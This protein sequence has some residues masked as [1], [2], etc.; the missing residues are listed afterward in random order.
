MYIVN[1][2]GDIDEKLQESVYEQMK[3]WAENHSDEDIAVNVNSIGG[4]IVIAQNINNL[5]YLAKEEKNANIVS[6]NTGDVMSAAT[7]IYLAGDERIWDESKG[8]FLIHR[9][10]IED[11]S[12]NVEEVLDGAIVLNET[13]ESLVEFYKSFNE[14]SMQEI[15]SRMCE[16]RP[17]STEEVIDYKF[18][19]ELI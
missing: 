17:M 9:P 14:K 10:I 7:V 18:A 5:I 1:V 3:E 11:L 8:A 4:D 15:F 2:V 12:G 16:D 19:T 6:Y 13:E